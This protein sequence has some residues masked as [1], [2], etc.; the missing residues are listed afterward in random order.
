MQMDSWPDKICAVIIPWIVRPACLMSVSFRVRL[1]AVALAEDWGVWGVFIPSKIFSH[2]LK[3]NNSQQKHICI[4]I[5]YWPAISHYPWLSPAGSF[6]NGGLRVTHSAAAFTTWDRA[7]PPFV[8]GRWENDLP[9]MEE[10]RQT[11]PLRLVVPSLSQYLGRVFF[12]KRPKGGYF[13]PDFW[14]PSTVTV[15]PWQSKILNPKIWR[16]MVDAR[17]LIF[18]LNPGLFLGCLAVHFPRS[19]LVKEVGGGYVCTGKG[20]EILTRT[21]T[22]QGNRLFVRQVL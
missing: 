16:W 4:M 8:L 3:H 21:W 1:M 14:L 20:G 11:H 5:F 6:P 15:P 22:L 10:I 18:L 17:W 7:S 12:F 2:F 13:S 9:L 19:R